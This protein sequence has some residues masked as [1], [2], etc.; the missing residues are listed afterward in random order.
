MLKKKI[1][2]IWH[3][4]AV[5]LL[6]LH[7]KKHQLILIYWYV[8][9]STVAGKFML[10]FGANALFLSPEYLGKVNGLAAAMVGVAIG[11]FIMA[12]NITTFILFSKHI[13]FLATAQ[14]PFLIYCLNNFI[15]PVCFLL[16]YFLKTIQYSLYKELLPT[17]T[18]FALILG[19]ILGLFLIITISFAYFFKADKTIGKNMQE[20][21]QTPIVNNKK[22]LQQY[23]ATSESN[24]IKVKSYL[25]NYNKVNLVRDVKHY[26]KMYI[27]K[28]FSRHHLA[29]V[30]L[31]LAAFIIL[32]ISSFFLDYKYFQIPAAASITVFFAILLSLFGAMAYFLQNWSLPFAIACLFIVNLLFK[33]QIIDPTNK[34]FGL[35]YITINRPI[36]DS[37]NIAQL[38]T[39]NKIDADKNT[40]LQILNNWK[41]RQKETL[42]IMY[43]INVSG[44]GTR[45]ATFTMHC[46]QQLDSTLHNDLMQKTFLITG[47][48]G[49]LLGATYYRELYNQKLLGK[50]ENYNDEKYIDNISKDLLNP[51]FSSL[52]ARDILSPGQQFTWQNKTYLKD[53]GYAFEQKL[54]ANTNFIMQKSISDYAVLEKDAVLP[55]LM[56]SNVIIRDARKM[57][58]STQPISYLMQAPA[59]AA[60][61]FSPS[62]DG[63]DFG[64]FFKNQ[65]ATQL[66]VLSALRMNASFPY[67]LPTVWLPTQPVINVMDAGIKDNFG[68]EITTRFL[69]VF[70][71]WL[72]KNVRKVVVISI[73]DRKT[74]NFETEN[75]D[76][77]VLNIFTKPVTQLQYNVFKIQD[78]MQTEQL[79]LLQQNFTIPLQKIVLQYAPTDKNTQAALNFHLTNKEKASIK[80]SIKNEENSKSIAKIKAA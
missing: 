25:I 54:N 38:C 50:I 76:K 34:A 60:N 79:S 31:I 69:Q 8:L 9:F 48:S 63:I 15:I 57:I 46:L 37:F 13:K 59:N 17:A 6:L 49:G 36:Y 1:Y 80:L 75:E 51:V 56:F 3:S 62:P 39:P 43:F 26:N 29:S 52:V 21:L 33:L 12:W 77:S 44:G 70:K 68:Q 19:F 35:N 11:V 78:Y 41:L 55:M 23:I 24:L 67:I 14:K 61:N 66:S 7:F 71:D 65:D 74:G 42:P 32:I 40:M 20:T 47:A 27:E 64:A 22:D 10:L 58:I 28:V 18:I 5:Q 2:N 45:S 16:Y 53:R 30:F 4:F 72:Q 73:R